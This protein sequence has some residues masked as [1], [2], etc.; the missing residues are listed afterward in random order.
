MGVRFRK[1]TGKWEVCIYRGG[2]RSRMSFALK[3]DAVDFE[4]AARLE[5]LGFAGIIKPLTFG[6]A[7]QDY[8]STRSARKVRASQIADARMLGL[9]QHFFEVERGLS[10]VS[11]VRVEDLELFMLWLAPARQAG[12]ISKEPWS[13]TTIARCMILVKSVFKKLFITDRLAKNPAAYVSVPRG[14][15]RRRRPMTAE[16]FERIVSIAPDWY[17]PVLLFLRL[18]G[19]RPA[20]AAALTWSDV[21]FS[22]ASLLLRS[23]K[24]A[25]NSEKIISF[26]MYPELMALM[27]KLAN[28]R[29]SE[30]VFLD[31]R[32]HPVTSMNISAHG[33]RLIKRAGLKGVVL[34]GLRHAMAVDMTRAGVSMEIIRQVLGHSNIEQTSVYARGIETD[35]LR[36]SLKLIRGGKTELPQDE[37]LSVSDDETQSRKPSE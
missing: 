8:L 3:K 23:K 4:R 37:E 5:L 11:Q 6:S 7:F 17:K 33:S 15:S 21:D 13:D 34:Y 27:A 36:Q 10:L 29:T 32:A 14:T 26:P 31:R 12:L 18:T 1:E 35:A 22:M 20:S 28:A 2:K 30:H 25:A 9:A 24:G 19:A 16:E